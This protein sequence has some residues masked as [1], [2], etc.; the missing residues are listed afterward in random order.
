MTNPRVKDLRGASRRNFIRLVGAAGAAFA[1]ERS[2]VL[3]YLLDEGGSAMA[4]TGSCASTNRSVHIIGGNGSFAWFQ[5]LWPHLEVADQA[6]AAKGFSYHSYDVA[7]SLYTPGGS[8]MPFFYAP[9]AP[10]VQ[11]GKPKYPVTGLMAGANET[12]TQTP[13]SAAIVA[14]NASMVGTVASIQ[15]ANASLLPVIGVDPV[16]FG[17]APGAPSIATVPNAP[18]MIELFNSAAS[19]LTLAAT[20][21]KQLYETYYKAI[22]S[23]REASGRPTVASRLDVTKTAANLIGRNLSMQLTPSAADLTAY[24]VTALQASQAFPNA[25]TRLEAL[26]RALCTT[27]KAFSLGLTNCVILGLAPGATSEQTFVD[28]HVVFDPSNAVAL[29]ATVKALGMIL[30]AFYKDLEGRTDPT[31][32]ASKLSQTTVLTVHGDT[33]HNPLQGDAWPDATPKN[34][35]WLYVMGGGFVRSGWFG[36]VRADGSVD[37]FDPTSGMAMPNKSAAE[38]ST[39]A[40]AAVAY[41]VSKGNMTLV[42]QFYTGPSIKGIVV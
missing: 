35:N 27:A 3:D 19:Q 17:A 22:L 37:G 24:G 2:R 28:P 31:C 4:D 42:N 14:N 13:T 25:K 30:D 9:E 12:H 16:N 29:K 18:G 26:A 36:G 8:D 38:T 32:M 23:L 1:V 34:S 6:N 41:A 7:G 21:D 11:N 40:G 39:A 5:L 20:K 33:P 10:W 15:R